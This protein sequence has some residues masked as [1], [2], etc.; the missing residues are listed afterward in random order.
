MAGP[1]NAIDGEHQT[2]SIEFYKRVFAHLTLDRDTVAADKAPTFPAGAE[3][4]FLED[5]F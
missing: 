1:I 4:M 3:T 5:T 2:V